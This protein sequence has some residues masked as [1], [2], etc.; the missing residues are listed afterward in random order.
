MS[1]A[2]QYLAASLGK[3]ILLGIAAAVVLN[4]IY[5]LAYRY[6]SGNPATLFEAFSWGII[7]IAPWIAAFELGRTSRNWFVLIAIF[8]AATSASLLLEAA[9]HSS[10]PTGFDLIRRIPA[11]TLFAMGLGLFAFLE[12]RNRDIE[13]G[14]F[15]SDM[16]GAECGS[17]CDYDWV[18]SAGNYIEMHRASDPPALKRSSLSQF[19]R[20]TGSRFVR[21]H[22]QY[23]VHPAAVR[24][25]ERKHVLLLDGTRLPIGNRYRAKVVKD[26]SLVP[27]SQ[28]T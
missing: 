15:N 17:D 26:N 7:N 9:L 8:L 2:K 27:S 18:M 25:F 23:A 21:V 28:T 22:R 12:A 20:D 3:R 6:A 1:L 19:L 5:C 13:R 16:V 11:A 4:A 14:A 10:L 24:Q